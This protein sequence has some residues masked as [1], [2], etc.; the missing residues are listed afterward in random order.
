MSPVPHS[1]QVEASRKHAR[2]EESEEESRNQQRLII[3]DETLHDG[4]EAEKEHVQAKP[5]IWT[6]FLEEDI[7]RNFE[8]ERTYVSSAFFDRE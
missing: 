6:E 5:D 1:D 7:A 4:D 3:L 8:A 2:F